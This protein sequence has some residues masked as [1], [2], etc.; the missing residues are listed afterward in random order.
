MSPEAPLPLTR[1]DTTREA[2]IAAAIE[3]FGRD[4]FDA[5]STRAISQ[6]AGV[7]QALIGYHFGGKPGLYLAAL[8]LIADSVIARVGPIVASIE[9]ELQAS[10]DGQ[11][12]DAGAE[13]ALARLHE[14]IDALV[15]MLTSDESAAWARLILREQQ[16]PSAGFDVLYE[17]IMRRVLGVTTQLIARARGAGARP[18]QCKLTAMTIIG[19]A[20]VFRAA[21]AAALRHMS[22]A[23]LSAP[24]IKAIQAEL[25]RNVVA[26]VNAEKDR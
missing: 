13:R 15:L 21:R 24:E 2:L 8:K 17:G 3:I 22:W 11:Q 12:S 19:Q 6:A 18:E 5:A 9:T 26:I 14:L 23:G 10:D 1:G 7:N 20:L 25:R 4:G 16:D